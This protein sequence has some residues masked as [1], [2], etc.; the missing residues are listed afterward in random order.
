[1]VYKVKTKTLERQNHNKMLKHRYSE[2]WMQTYHLQGS[3]NRWPRHEHMLRD[4]HLMLGNKENSSVYLKTN[5]SITFNMTLGTEV[6][7]LS[8]YAHWREVRIQGPS[9]IS[10]DV[11]AST[12]QR[13]LQPVELMPSTA[14]P[15]LNGITVPK[16]HNIPRL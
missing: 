1:M 10:V 3:Y 6:V 5:T 16:N 2:I 11:C 13:L 7:R 4:I 14:Y 8:V 12:I 15:R 9:R